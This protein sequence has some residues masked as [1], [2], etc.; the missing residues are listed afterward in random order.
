MI[1]ETKKF[2]ILTVGA[3]ISGGFTHTSEL[4]PMKYDEAMKKDP[5]G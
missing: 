5:I 1:S 3:G 2:K 4:I